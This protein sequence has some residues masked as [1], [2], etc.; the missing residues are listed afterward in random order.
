MHVRAASTL[1]QRGV[2]VLAVALEAQEERHVV[3]AGDVVVELL[4]GQ[5]EVG[6]QLARRVLDGVAE[7]D[8]ADRAAPRPTAQ[9]SI[10]I[11]LT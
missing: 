10:A 9:H 6:G 5:P 8:G 4:G 1:A 11:G 2:E 3:D 7:P